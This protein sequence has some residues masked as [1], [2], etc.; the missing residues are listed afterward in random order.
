MFENTIIKLM[1]YYKD[2]DDW[3]YLDTH[4]K[5]Y[6]DKFFSNKDDLDDYVSWKV[7]T[8]PDSST[9]PPTS[10][11]VLPLTLKA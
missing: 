8:P 4:G 5:I 9:R 7:T 10:I 3:Y 11:D 2:K 1:K 6:G